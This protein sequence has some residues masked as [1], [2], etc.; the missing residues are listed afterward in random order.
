MHCVVFINP[1]LILLYASV[2][3][4][5]AC[6]CGW[7]YGTLDGA[8]IIASLYWKLQRYKLQQLL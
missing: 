4:H 7:L 3:N 1:K 6:L 8:A 2:F 5:F